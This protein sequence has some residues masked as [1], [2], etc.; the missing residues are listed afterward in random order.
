[1]YRMRSNDAQRQL[2]GAVVFKDHEAVEFREVKY[3]A[4]A[5]QGSGYGKKLMDALKKDSVDTRMF[6]IVLYASNTAVTFFEKQFFHNFP[7][8]ICG[9]SKTV[10]LTRIEQYQ[11]STLMACDLIDIF[12]ASYPEPGTNVRVGD[13]VVVS[14]GL[15][16][17]RNEEA[18]VIETK[19]PWKVKVSYPRWTSDSDEWIVIS[20]KRLKLTNEE[21]RNNDH[22]QTPSEESVFGIIKRIRIIGLK[23]VNQK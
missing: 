5:Y 18:E 19:G 17:A 23:K 16:H 8:N 14:H 6:Y 13:R 22:V 9:L 11:R 4:T 20:A 3:F 1:M 2:I 21:S 15:R 12:P 10:V 7:A